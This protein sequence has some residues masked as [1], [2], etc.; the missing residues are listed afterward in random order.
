MRLI[1]RPAQSQTVMT[2]ENGERQ[3]VKVALAEPDPPPMEV[4]AKSSPSTPIAPTV[5]AKAPTNPVTA[6]AL[7][8]LRT[9]AVSKP[10]PPPRSERVSKPEPKRESNLKG[11]PPSAPPV[12]AKGKPAKVENSRGTR[13]AGQQESV[14][15]PNPRKAT[16][17][18]GARKPTPTS[19][20]RP[21]RQR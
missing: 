2:S 19:R 4:S 21:T 5:T 15:A 1:V 7:G 14:K 12:T 17:P 10:A 3:V 13:R 20:G 18:K 16:E 11:R 6:P 8:P 9:A